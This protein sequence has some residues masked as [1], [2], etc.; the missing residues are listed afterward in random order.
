M[1]FMEIIPAIL[2][3][4]ALEFKRKLAILEG[5]VETAQFDIMDGRFVP[6]KTFADPLKIRSWASNLKFELHLMVEDPEPWIEAWREEPRV[7]RVIIHAEI[8]RPLAVLIE[9]IKD[10]GWEVGLALNPET[11]WREIDE[12][13]PELETALVMTVQ[14]GK[15]GQPFEEAVSKYHLLAKIN[16]LRQ[17][18]PNL[19][20]SVDGGVSDKTLPLLLEAGAT[21]FA[22]G[23]AIWQAPDPRQALL[24]LQNLIHSLV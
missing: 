7:R 18:H 5:R 23:S 11:S 15:S 1:I 10:Q 2:A 12:Y 17:A 14:P 22:V 9:K 13:I 3:K 24:K 21:R 16:D 20:I 19:V 4:E 8:D 6:A